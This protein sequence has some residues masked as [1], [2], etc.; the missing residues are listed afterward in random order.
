[1]VVYV[2]IV[3][4]TNFVLDFGLL[5]ATA[6]VRKIKPNLWRV[7]FASLIGASYVIMMFIPALSF[8]YTFVVK[9]LF[10]AAMIMTAFGYKT[11]GR[12]GGTLAAFYG[13]N[14][15]AAGT[16]LGIHYVT[17][18]PNDIVNGIVFSQTGGAMHTL[19]ISMWFVLFMAVL[20]ILWFRFVHSG[21]KRRETK[22]QFLTE[23][24][25][26]IDETTIRCQGLIDTG[27]HLYDP[28]TRTPVMVM[29]ASL[30]GR[31]VPEEWL[32]AIRSGEADAIIL[33]L[34]EEGERET[35][36]WRDRIRLV[37]YRGI[38]GRSRFMLALKPDTVT[39]IRS[40]T[41]TEVDKVLIGL[42]GGQLSS[43]GAYQA[44]VHPA[45]VG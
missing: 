15:A 34:D 1:M 37:P 29:E 28:L 17:R 13:V 7:G 3:F 19:G 39:I 8:F 16:I 41:R 36:P 12:F 10:S 9:C 44:I 11:L 31:F 42:D 32:E 6:H 2:D 24:E 21:A 5:L 4:L 45:L 38:N 43:E 14:F 23:V 18:S 27:N 33:R 35:F 22:A 25:V 20:G 26:T 40:G 30:W